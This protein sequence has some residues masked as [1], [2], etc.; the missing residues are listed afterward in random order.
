M[1]IYMHILN[2]MTHNY[3]ERKKKI[4]YKDGV[5]NRGGI[6]TNCNQHKDMI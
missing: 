1:Q 6:L 5:H 4:M 2:F 3:A